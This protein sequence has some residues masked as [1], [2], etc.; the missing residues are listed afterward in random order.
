M[1]G[2]FLSTMVARNSK[3]KQLLLNSIFQKILKIWLEIRFLARNYKMD[4]KEIRSTAG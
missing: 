4:K 1:I 3:Y 2:G